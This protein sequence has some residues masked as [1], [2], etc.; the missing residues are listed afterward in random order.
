[1][2]AVRI[3]SL[4]SFTELPCIGQVAQH[5]EKMLLKQDGVIWRDLSIK[6]AL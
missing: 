3:G 6:G 4:K 1:M 5:N 2:Q